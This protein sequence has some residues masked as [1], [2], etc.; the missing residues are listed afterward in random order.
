MNSAAAAVAKAPTSYI[1]PATLDSL[2]RY[3]RPVALTSDRAR[4]EP[5][6]LFAREDF[7]AQPREFGAMNDGAL[8]PDSPVQGWVVS[9]ILVTDVQRMAIVNNSVV[10][11]GSTLAGGAQVVDIQP[12]RVVLQVAGSGRRVISLNR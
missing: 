8:V 12:D 7:Y 10:V 5:A 9:A 3:L 6:E 4:T 2:A 1:A 11:V